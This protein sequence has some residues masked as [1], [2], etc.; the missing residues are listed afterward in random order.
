MALA[1]RCSLSLHLSGPHR[2]Q[3][4]LARKSACRK[5][6]SVDP[7]SLSYKQM[8]TTTRDRQSS[9]ASF[10]LVESS[11]RS[12]TFKV[13]RKVRLLYLPVEALN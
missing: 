7:K 6:N 5:A 4:E 12:E 9:T 1:D 11:S 10:S 8:S 3:T 13:S 2:T